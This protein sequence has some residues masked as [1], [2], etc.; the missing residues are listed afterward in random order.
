MG[1]HHHN[2]GT[3]RFYTMDRLRAADGT[4]TMGLDRTR[5]RGGCAKDHLLH[6]QDLDVPAELR[7]R[8]LGD[9]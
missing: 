5:K 2:P 6:T 8:R 4:A 7:A 9:T 3:K 1:V